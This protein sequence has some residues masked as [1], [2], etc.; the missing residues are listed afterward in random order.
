[1]N[2]TLLMPFVDESENFTNG[3]ECGQLWE[4][5]TN[6]AVFENQLIHSENKEQIILM[7]VHFG[8]EYKIVDCGD[9]C[10]CFLSGNPINISSVLT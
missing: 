1:M 6:D 3:F 8:Y 7:L 5:M 9:G 4:K 2:S 10:W